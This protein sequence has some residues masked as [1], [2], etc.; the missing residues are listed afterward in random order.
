MSKSLTLMKAVPEVGIS[1]PL[2]EVALAKALPKSRETPITS[3]VDF[4]SGPSRVSAPGN[5]TK[6]KTASYT[7]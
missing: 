5:F 4:I 3:P 2:A 1:K 6:G 7:E